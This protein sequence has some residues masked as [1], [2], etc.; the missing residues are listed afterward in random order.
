MR[1]MFENFMKRLGSLGDE[2]LWE[3]YID[4]YLKKGQ[5]LRAYYYQTKWKPKSYFSAISKLKS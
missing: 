2:H 5:V 1:Q 3:Y 4:F